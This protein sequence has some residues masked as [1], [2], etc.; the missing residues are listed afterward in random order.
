LK[1]REKE[2]HAAIE[3]SQR[4]EVVLF[5]LSHELEQTT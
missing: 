4:G 2:C 3:R 1:S 5:H